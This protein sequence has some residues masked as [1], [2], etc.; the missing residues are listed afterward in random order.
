M[1]ELKL[2]EYAKYCVAWRERK[3]F[4]TSWQNML[5][6]LML[7]V[8]ELGEAA[9]AYRHN[10]RANFKEEI[11][12]TFIRLLDITGTLDMDIEK[13]IIEK[14]GYNET[15]PLQHGKVMGDVKERAE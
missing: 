6:K 13:A 2:N 14:M 10:D 9:E 12:D 11:A 5:E 3:G 15:R 1:K 7:V 8:S 4:V